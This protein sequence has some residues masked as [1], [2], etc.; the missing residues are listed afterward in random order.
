MKN[1]E[2]TLPDRLLRP[3]IDQLLKL[4]VQEITVEPVRVFKK[5]LHQTLIYRGC[6]YEQNYVTESKLRFLAAEQDA[7]QA[8]AILAD[9]ARN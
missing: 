1:F 4:N 7:A 9:A 8:E 5:R 2:T 3:T 6:E